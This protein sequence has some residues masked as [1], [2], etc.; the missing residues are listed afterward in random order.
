M[1]LLQTGI[2]DAIKISNCGSWL[3]LSQELSLFGL[4]TLPHKI[5]NIILYD[6]QIFYGIIIFM[7]I[8]CHYGRLFMNAFR[9][10][11]D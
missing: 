6:A 4:H 7:L 3:Q 9:Q 2:L 1:H 10:H 8:V 5:G 11:Y